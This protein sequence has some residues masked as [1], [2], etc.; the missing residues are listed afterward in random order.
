MNKEEMNEIKIW[1]DFVQKRCVL[2]HSF[3]LR[4]LIDVTDELKWHH[5]EENEW[6]FD[7]LTLEEIYKQCKGLHP[8]EIIYAI[9]DDPLH[10]TIYQCGN[11]EEGQ[12]IE[13]GKGMGYA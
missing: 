2:V 4:K 1:D 9:Q 5:I 7:Y 12:W 11:Y 10:T 8:S 13:W 3:E 6:E